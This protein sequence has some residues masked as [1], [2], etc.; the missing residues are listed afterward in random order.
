MKASLLSLSL[1]SLFTVTPAFAE[2]EVIMYCRLHQIEP[3]YVIVEREVTTDVWTVS[4]M[5]IKQNIQH[6]Y[7]ASRIGISVK[8]TSFSNLAVD[9]QFPTEDG[10]QVI[11]GRLQGKLVTS[12]V[13]EF[14]NGNEIS[15]KECNVFST[16]FNFHTPGLRSENLT[17]VD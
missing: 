16:R 2:Q 4:E 15:S 5:G 7:P 1:L 14:K 3:I 8:G 11:S 6:S 12:Q 13:K 10:L 17:T 9:L